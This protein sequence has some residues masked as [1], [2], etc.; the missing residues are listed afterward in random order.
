MIHFK[1]LSLGCSITQQQMADV[2]QRQKPGGRGGVGWGLR[3]GGEQLWV[4]DGQMERG[5]GGQSWAELL[6]NQG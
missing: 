5:W 2:G 3:P 1:P 4:P 6:V